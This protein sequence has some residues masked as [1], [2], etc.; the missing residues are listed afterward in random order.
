MA[1]GLA[2][3]FKGRSATGVA[4]FV[5]L[6][7][8]GTRGGLRVVVEPV[9]EGCALTAADVLVLLKIW[10]EADDVVRGVVSHPDSSRIAYF[11]GNHTLVELA[12]A[13]GLQL[14]RTGMTS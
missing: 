5:R 2:M 3:E 6:G 4:V 10:R 13:I 1:Y 7:A 12:Q 8:A 14:T 11:Q 9:E